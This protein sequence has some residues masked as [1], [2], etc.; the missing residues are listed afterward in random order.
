MS[1][2]VGD[3]EYVCIQESMEEEYAEFLYCQHWN[4]E[5]LFMNQI[6]VRIEAEGTAQIIMEYYEP[7]V[8]AAATM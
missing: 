7:P 1:A 8:I 3:L 4:E 2:C 6:L 5:Y